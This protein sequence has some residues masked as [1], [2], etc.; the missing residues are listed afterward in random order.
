MAR[1]RD[2]HDARQAALAALGKDLSRR[3]GSACELCGG[4][5]TPRPV[6]VPPPKIPDLDNAI[7]ACACCRGLLEGGRLPDADDLRFLETAIW[8]E[9]GPVQIAAVRLLRRL[10]AEEIDWAQEAESGLWLDDEV[11]ERI[12]AD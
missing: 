11:Q 2:R 5:D 10:V 7:L 12:S 9:V 6:L 1:G 8:S 3:G 4:K